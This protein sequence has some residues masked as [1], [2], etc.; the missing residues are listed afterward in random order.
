MN[1]LT[2]NKSHGLSGFDLK[3][4]AIICMTFDHI[5]FVFYDVMPFADTMRFFGRFTFP[6][7]VMMIAEGYRYSKNRDR[8]FV[9][10]MFF[11]VLSMIP[12]SLIH[13]GK[14]YNVLFTLAAG[15]LLLMYEDIIHSEFGVDKR[16][17][18]LVFILLAFLFSW[19]LRS[20]DWAF[21]GIVTIYVAGKIDNIKVRSVVIPL[22]LFIGCFVPKLFGESLYLSSVIFY[23]GILFSIPVLLLY[24]GQKGKSF[25]GVMK[26][27]FYIYYPL[28]FAVIALAQYISTMI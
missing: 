8:Y 6:V 7:M 23:S 12:Y 17:L 24:N 4:I 28:H 21:P 18:S 9:R 20:C 19:L 27:G 14:P 10:L 26:Y 22:M 25:D 3:C 16:I 5:G 11:A 2:S 15:L 13:D 1:E